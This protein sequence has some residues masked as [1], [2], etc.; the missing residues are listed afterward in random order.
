MSVRETEQSLDLCMRVCV[1]ACSE[2]V[3]PD[4]QAWLFI[5]Q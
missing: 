3:E 2:L 4:S 1:C 5:W